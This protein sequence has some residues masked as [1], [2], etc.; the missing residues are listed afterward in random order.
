MQVQGL[1]DYGV[2]VHRPPKADWVVVEARHLSPEE[3]K[4]KHHIY[5]DALDEHGKRVE[6][7]RL[8][9]GWD[10]GGE[11]PPIKMDKPIG[12]PM[13]NIPVYKGQMI[14]VWMGEHSDVVTGLHTMHPD[15]LGPNGEKWNSVGHH[16]F[17]I[18]FQKVGQAAKKVCACC[19]R[20]L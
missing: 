13:C 10:G 14:A 12:E 19:G 5:V 8:C 9:W 4:G 16:S 6:G 17:Y 7:A 2:R 11:Q 15:E 1:V 18:C 3:N 20:E